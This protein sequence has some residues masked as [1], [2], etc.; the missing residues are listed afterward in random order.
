MKPSPSAFLFDLNG[1]MIDDMAFHLDAWHHILNNELGAHLSRE[2]VKGEMYGKNT[3]LLVRVFGPRRF[4]AD[5]MERI[6]V[7]KERRYQAVFRP[8]LQLIAG[9]DTF[10]KTA[11]SQGIKMAIGS[12]AIP[13]NIDFVL[14][15]LNLRPY[16]GAIVSADDVT[17]SKPDGETFA[18][19]AQRLN[20]A[21]AD[22]LV[23]EDAPKGVEAANNA[24]MPAVVLTTMHR[25]EEFKPY[26]N[27]RYF[28]SDYTDPRL[29]QLISETVVA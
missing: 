29:Q 25:E 20:V 22:C 3:E 1:T 26:P 11:Y 18:K 10:L 27:I 4:S 28:V 19:A 14:D 5:E 24:G 15:G 12:A 13:M 16:F 9:L 7:E 6:S 8:H 2:E 17:Q 23:F 21:P